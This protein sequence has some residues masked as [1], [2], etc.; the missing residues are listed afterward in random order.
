VQRRGLGLECALELASH[1]LT[2]RITMGYEGVDSSALRFCSKAQSLSKFS[3]PSRL[4]APEM[5][6]L[7]TVGD[8]SPVAY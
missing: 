7:F 8:V 1:L 4:E 2:T 6:T 3:L 5:K